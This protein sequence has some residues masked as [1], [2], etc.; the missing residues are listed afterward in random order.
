MPSL[1][2]LDLVLQNKGFEKL[3]PLQKLN[4]NLKR[5]IKQYHDL[6]YG[7]PILGKQNFDEYCLKVTWNFLSS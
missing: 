4:N 5:P 3:K 7:I 6:G 2:K 1:Q